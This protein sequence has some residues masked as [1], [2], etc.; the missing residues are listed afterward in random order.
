M[1]TE[2]DPAVLGRL[3]ELQDEDTAV[4]R[5]EERRASLPEAHRLSELRDQVAELEADL[6]IARKQLDEIAREQGR[7][8]GETELT[9]QKIQ[10]E[11]QRLFA[12]IVSNPKELSSLQA[13]VEMLKRRKAGLEDELLEVLVQRDQAAETATSL[14]AEWRDMK[15]EAD[16]LTRTV[17]DLTGTIDTE[18]AAHRE[19]RS[20]VASAVPGD[21]LQLYERLR[22]QKGGIAAAALRDGTCQG[23]HT[24]LPAKEVERVRSERGLQRCDNCRRILVVL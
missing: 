20:T 4:K 3:L 23:C 1:P 15:T 19:A 11:E 22:A 5:L 24:K 18:L 12:G 2:V 21:L 6:A 10:R 8:E 9:T 7:L 17:A 14:E 13:E 16:E